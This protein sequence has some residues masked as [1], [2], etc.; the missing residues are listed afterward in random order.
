MSFSPLA[1]KSIEFI[2]S[3]FSRKTFATLNERTTESVSFIIILI[4]GICE[5]LN[6]V[7]QPIVC[8]FLNVVNTEKINFKRIV[9][10]R[11]V[12]R[13]EISVVDSSRPNRLSPCVQIGSNAAYN[14]KLKFRENLCNT[15]LS[16]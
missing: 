11:F 5:R 4:D 13:G 6:C 9:Y 1:E 15:S 10:I 3:E 8:C 7:I 14:L 12:F 16:K 2:L